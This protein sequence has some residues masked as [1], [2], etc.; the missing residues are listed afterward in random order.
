MTDSDTPDLPKLLPEAVH[1][2]VR[3][4]TALV[5]LETTR[6]REGVLDGAWW[7]RSRDIGAE[8][9]GLITALTEHLGPVARV[10][11][12]ASAWEELPTRLVI[13]DR[14]VHIDSFPVGDDTI[15][16]TRG[17]QDHFSLLVVPPTAT[18]EAA[19]AAMNRA[20]Q[21][22]NVAQAGQILIDTGSGPPP[23]S[24]AEG[25]RTGR[26]PSGST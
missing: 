20:V 7:P 11:L 18:A 12:D 13:E 9:P 21:A 8:L 3:P 25:P 22:D 1:H 14:I 4:G 23:P 17:D 19:H 15:L 5:R 26:E 2:E 10:G 16:I 24:P 6:S